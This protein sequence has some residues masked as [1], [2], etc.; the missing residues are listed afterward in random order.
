[1]SVYNEIALRQIDSLLTALSNM[2]LDWRTLAETSAGQA[3]VMLNIE[4][5]AFIVRVEAMIER[6]IPNGDPFRRSFQYSIR[7]DEVDVKVKLLRLRAT[8]TALREEYANGFRQS[9]P[10][11]IHGEVFG[12]FLDMADHLH[13]QGYI[14]AAAVIAGTVLE[15]HVRKLAAKCNLSLTDPNGKTK[16]V[17]TLNQELAKAGT[18]KGSVQKQITAWY[19]LRNEAAHGT[20]QPQDYGPV[21][22]MVMGVRSFAALYPA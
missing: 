11:L 10:E 13:T 15:E 2:R 21:G 4:S 12:D 22:P 19:G 16:K 7:D 5:Q 3:E 1:M 8:L 17:E 14:V 6:L 18:Y 9:L 20:L